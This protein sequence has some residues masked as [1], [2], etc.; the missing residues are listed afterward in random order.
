MPAAD[1]WYVGVGYTLT[2]FVLA[3]Y[4]ARLHRRVRRAMRKTAGRRGAS[5]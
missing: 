2:G 3:T 4:A 5:P 1:W